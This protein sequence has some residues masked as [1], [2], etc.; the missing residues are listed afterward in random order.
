MGKTD[1]HR[2]DGC[3]EFP[4][5]PQIW[6]LF[7]FRLLYRT[8]SKILSLTE[9]TNRYIVNALLFHNARPWTPQYTLRYYASRFPYP[10]R[11]PSYG[12]FRVCNV[13]Q[14]ALS[15]AVPSQSLLHN[16]LYVGFPSIAAI[17]NS[18]IQ[19]ECE[20]VFARRIVNTD[21]TARK[22]NPKEIVQ[23]PP[24]PWRRGQ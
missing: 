2:Q 22:T 21:A 8:N 10:H 19:C 17:R 4:V 12:K 16:S 1:S 5:Q 9:H 15:D 3:A 20:W 18:F 23:Q 14:R 13:R 7:C 11:S 24:K 6:H